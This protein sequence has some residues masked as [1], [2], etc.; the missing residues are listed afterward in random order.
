M[1]RRAVVL[2]M[3]TVSLPLSAG[4]VFDFQCKSASS[5]TY[6]FRGRAVIE[7]PNAR[8]DVV[9]GAH[10]VFNPAITIISRD[11][12][13]N[14]LIIDHRLKT[15]F[16]RR[17][18]SMSGPSSTWK[19]PGQMSA[20]RGWV[21]IERAAEPGET[22]AGHATTKYTAVT[23]YAIAMQVEGEKMNAQVTARASL[24]MMNGKGITALPFGLHFALK[25]GFPS[26]D[27]RVAN[28]LAG[29]GIPLR[30]IVTVTRTIAGGAPVS[31]TFE[32]NVDTVREE[33]AA[34]ATFQAPAGYAYRE[35]TFGYSE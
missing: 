32:L 29:K 11:G 8:Y 18:A 26:I 20:S 15:W 16:M 33:K 13:R 10:P 24:W 3:F 6:T 23:E 25:P 31:E 1:L 12:G 35:P 17:T 7:G 22:I 14:L 34:D 9:D 2:A 19:A 27:E 30:Q 28:R 21:Q 4:Y 5:V